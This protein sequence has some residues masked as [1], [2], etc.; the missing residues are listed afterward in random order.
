Q[1]LQT[2]HEK[3]RQQLAESD[4]KLQ[5]CIS[6]KEALDKEEASLINKLKEEIDSARK[7]IMESERDVAAHEN[8][9]L[10]EEEEV[11]KI[12][13][14]IQSE[15]RQFMREMTETIKQ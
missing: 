12:Q 4:A 8:Q 15:K 13:T 14:D 11:S 1:E 2:L 5:K 10:H 6:E 3:K 9:L 7:Q